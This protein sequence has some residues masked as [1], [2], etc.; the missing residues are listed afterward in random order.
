MLTFTVACSE[1]SLS[2]QY[3]GLRP[4]LKIHWGLFRVKQ[5]GGHLVQLV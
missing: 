5:V 4:P 3:L 1:Y 2:L